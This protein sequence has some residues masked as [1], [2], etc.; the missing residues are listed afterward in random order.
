MKINRWK[1]PKWPAMS[2]DFNTIEHLW[3]DIKIALGR[4]HPSNMR[5]MEQFAEEEWSKNSTW[6]VKDTSWW[7]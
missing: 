5:E 1:V 4:N 6:G 7:L 3:K 2:P